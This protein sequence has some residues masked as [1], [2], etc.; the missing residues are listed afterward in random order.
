MSSPNP[1][2]RRV[3]LD[4]RLVIGLLLVVASVAATTLLVGAADARIRVYAAGGDLAPGD[5]V[6]VDDL[7]ERSVALDGAEGLYLGVGDLPDGG[8][9]AAQ[10]VAAGQLVPVSAAGSVDGERA[11]SLVLRLSGP[12]SSVVESGSLVDVWGVAVL[13]QGET[14]TPVVLAAGATVVRVIADESLVGATGAAASVEV[15][16]PRT[17]VARLLRA[18]ASGDA[19]AVVPAGLP[20]ASR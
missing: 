16:V 17:R 13:G 10:P 9:V 7:V 15:L 2:R 6:G 14:G 1:R 20:L 8:F 3:V 4:V 18:I 12:V 5:R 11:T 19:L